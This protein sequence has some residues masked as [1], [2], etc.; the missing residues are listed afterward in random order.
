VFENLET[1]GAIQKYAVIKEA[2]TGYSVVGLCDIR[3]LEQAQRR[4]ADY[5]HFYNQS[6]PQ[7]KLK[8][9]TPVQY[10]RQFAV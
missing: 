2:V 7:R 9:L 10:R 8:K 1:E 5:V 4:I 3:S 6:H